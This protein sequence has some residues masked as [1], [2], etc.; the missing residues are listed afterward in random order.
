MTKQKN[1]LNSKLIVILGPT[2][3]GKSDL[4][5][6]I[7]LRLSSGQ[8]RKKYGING[9]EIISADS[10]QVYHGMNLGTGKVPQDSISPL[11]DSKHP[12]A[13]GQ[14]Y[15]YRGIA[16]HLLD[17]ANP[18]RRFT[19]AQFKKL[20]LKAI[21]DI[22][23]RGKIPVI[24][25]GTGFYIRVIT[26]NLQIP[27]VKPDL[28]LR[29]ELEKKTT[30]ELYDELRKLD[31]NRAAIID[32]YNPRR[33][34][35]ALEIILKTGKPVPLL[36]SQNVIPAK[37]EIQ[38]NESGSRVTRPNTSGGREPGMTQNSFNTLFLSLKKSPA[39]LKILIRKRLFRRFR[40]GMVA[41]VKKLRASGLSW[42]RLDGF[43]LEYRWITKFLQ[44]KISREEM[45]TRLQKDIEH[46][47]KRQMTWFKKYPGEKIHWIKKTKKAN[48]LINNFLAK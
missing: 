39:E 32:P 30:R 26:D 17:I 41:E 36:I 43:G 35:R 13:V 19:V 44:K 5:V 45:V 48:K 20:A 16:H 40:Q 15:F 10:R 7:A 23:R 47:A 28:K 27:E 21:K 18:K 4:A 3:S 12:I 6:E 29:A 24:C 42:K 34:I 11:S 37:A 22:Q 25:G 33:L 8:A 9:A 2:A 38:V 1:R 14:R 31:P 46:Y